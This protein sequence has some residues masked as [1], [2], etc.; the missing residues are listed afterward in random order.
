MKSRII[1]LPE[2]NIWNDFVAGSANPSVLQSYEWGEFKAQFGWQPLRI[3]LDEG[4]A[5]VAGVSLLKREV[6]FIRHSFLYAPRG[7]IVIL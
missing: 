3:L 5:P 6:P 4:R 7:P 2:K 1:T